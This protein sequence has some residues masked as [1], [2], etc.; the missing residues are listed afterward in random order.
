[1]VTK[2]VNL[3]IIIWGAQKGRN[4]NTD[5]KIQEKISHAG[6][7]GGGRVNTLETG[8][9]EYSQPTEYKG[10]NRSRCRKK[11]RDRG[12]LTNCRAQTD[13]QIRTARKSERPKSTH[14]LSSVDGQTSQDSN[15]NRET[16]G[17]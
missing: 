8:E 2:D 10:R 4:E 6:E 13:G 1:L 14:A 7:L 3:E 17:H 5:E 12:A 9:K 11:V 16:E 15:R